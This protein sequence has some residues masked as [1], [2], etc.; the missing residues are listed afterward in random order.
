MKAVPVVSL[1]WEHI[2][3]GQPEGILLH[4]RLVPLGP[5]LLVELDQVVLY[6]K[7]EQPLGGLLVQLVVAVHVSRESRQRGDLLLRPYS[8]RGINVNIHRISN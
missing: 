1:V 2:I 4:P 6:G 3:C 7:V 5:H 8:L